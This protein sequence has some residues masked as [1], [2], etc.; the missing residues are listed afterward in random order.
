MLRIDG[1]PNLT[2]SRNLSIQAGST[3]ATLTIRISKGSNQRD[4]VF[5]LTIETESND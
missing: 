3:S 5:R 2:E 4:Y 1:H